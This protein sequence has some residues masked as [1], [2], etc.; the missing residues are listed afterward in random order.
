MWLQNLEFWPWQFLGYLC[1]VFIL[2]PTY[3]IWGS[4]PVFIIGG[5]AFACV[6][7]MQISDWLARQQLR[8]PRAEVLGERRDVV[9]KTTLSRRSPDV[10]GE[11]D[12]APPR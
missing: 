8:R 10:R 5:I 2:L 1:A 3:W 4:T 7:M 11:V 12:E 9:R 6:A